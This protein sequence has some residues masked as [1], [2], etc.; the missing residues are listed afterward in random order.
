MIGRELSEADLADLANFADLV[1]DETLSLP[2]FVL[3]TLALLVDFIP[4]DFDVD[5]SADVDAADGAAD[6]AAVTSCGGAVPVFEVLF[7]DFANL[8]DLLVDAAVAAFPSEELSN[9]A[10]DLVPFVDLVDFADT[11]V[12]SSADPS[13]NDL[14]FRRPRRSF[15]WLP[16]C[17]WASTQEVIASNWARIKV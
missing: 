5:S 17:G 13:P 10:L 1:F 4:L 11:G 16:M 7:A 9:Q 12:S 8:A 2:D 6:G 3:G 14:E 15:P